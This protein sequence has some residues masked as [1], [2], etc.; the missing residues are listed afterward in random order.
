MWR[1]VLRM[2]SHI[3][4]FDWFTKNA[5]K[6]DKYAGKW[7]AVLKGKLLAVS[8]SPKDLMKDPQVKGAKNPFIT[9]IPL[10]EEAFSLL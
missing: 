8:D 4:T 9:K 7:I 5:A 2:Y 6:F 10:K 3:E 1:K